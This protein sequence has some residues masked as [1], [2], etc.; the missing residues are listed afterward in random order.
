MEG[1]L[2]TVVGENEVFGLEGVDELAGFGA[3]EG[4]DDDEAGANGDGGRGWVS[5][6]VGW[7]I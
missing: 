6:G 4:G 3:H 1:L 5:L 7:G 2:D